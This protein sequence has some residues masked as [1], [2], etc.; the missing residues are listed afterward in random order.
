MVTDIVSGHTSSWFY[1]FFVCVSR[2]DASDSPIAKS[3]QKSN[4]LLSDS[5]SSLVVKPDKGQIT[6]VQQ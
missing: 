2:D 1:H 4:N 3:T 5:R 6:A